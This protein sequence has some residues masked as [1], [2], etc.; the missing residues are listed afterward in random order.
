MATCN[1]KHRDVLCHA[2]EV[3]MIAPEPTTILKIKAH[4]GH[5][6]NERA[7]A[8][9]RRATTRPGD[10][11]ADIVLPVSSRPSC[12]SCTRATA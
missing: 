12:K 5:I 6:G 11:P 10:T 7:D 2:L 8:V 4:V 3:I 1:H 9:T